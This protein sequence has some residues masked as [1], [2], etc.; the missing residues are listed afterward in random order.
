MVSLVLGLVRELVLHSM[1]WDLLFWAN[2]EL[3]ST[4]TTFYVQV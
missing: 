3:L 2:T 4:L 1:P